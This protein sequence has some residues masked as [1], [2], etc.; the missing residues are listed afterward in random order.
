MLRYHHLFAALLNLQFAMQLFRSQ[1]NWG[2][3]VVS[4]LK[5]VFL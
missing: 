3:K 1:G 2:L 4:G 5:I